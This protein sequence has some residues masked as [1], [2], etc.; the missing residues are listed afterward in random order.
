[1]LDMSQ[2]TLNIVNEERKGRDGDLKK[3]LN[4][5]FSS[6]VIF[7]SICVIAALIAIFAMLI[8]ESLPALK[9]IGW[10]FLSSGEWY[11]TYNNAEFGMLYMIL[12]S[13]ILVGLT[14]TVV[15]S[16]GL[17]IALYITE[18]ANRKEQEV[19]RSVTE[20]ISGIPSVVVGLIGVLLIGPLMLKIGAWTPFNLL[21]AGISLTI[22]TLPYAISLLIESLQSVNRD[23][24]EAAWALGSSKIKATAVVL[25]GAK[26]EMLYALVLIINRILG[27]TM[28][29]LMVAGGA[30]MLPKSLFDPIRPLTA[31]IASEMG[32]VELGSLH[33]S[34]LFL[35]GVVLLAISTAITVTT[36]FFIRKGK[37]WLIG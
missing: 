22:L 36:E 32:E 14:S 10:G 19:V 23:L 26:H 33:Y 1:M 25:R 15:F 24:R 13:L 2:R 29:V 6:V 7:V 31:A 35:M 4:S 28:V 21:N 30:V 18:Y 34:A 17:G 20:L 9:E 37:R 8:H 12:D 16:M 11:P 27:E 5:L 3:L